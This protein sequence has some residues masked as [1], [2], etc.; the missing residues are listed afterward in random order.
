MVKVVNNERSIV[1]CLVLY[2]SEDPTHKQAIEIIQHNYSYALIE[3]NS[4]INE[5]G[6]LKKSHTHIVLKFNNYKWKLSL[7]KELGIT[8]NYLEKCRNLEKA[9]KYLIHLENEDKFQYDIDLVHG[10]LKA[11]LKNYIRN[12]NL[13]ESEKVLQL[14]DFI[15]TYD[16]KLKISEFIQVCCQ[17]NMYDIYR[18]SQFSFNK[19][20]EEHNYEIWEK[21]QYKY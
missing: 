13:S 2:P 15:N 5:D 8:P 3:H 21:N 10:D 11:K 20:I 18:R 4:D 6:Q 12:K 7:A 17:L 1:W 16:R 19:I 9:L 14:I